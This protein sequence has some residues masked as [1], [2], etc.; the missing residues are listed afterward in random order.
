MVEPPVADWPVGCWMPRS[1][2]LSALRA[3]ARRSLLLAAGQSLAGLSELAARCG[4]S[5]PTPDGTDGLADS[6]SSRPLILTGHQPV[7]FHPGLVYKYQLTEAHAASA[8]GVSV[9]IVIDTDEGDPGQFAVPLV[10]TAATATAAAV[11]SGS[12]VETFAAGGGLYAGCRLLPKPDREAVVARVSADLTAAGCVEAGGAFEAAASRYLQLSDMPMW[13]ANTI[14]RRV[15]GIGS[16]MF[17]LPLTAV[18]RLPESL[19]LFA[20]VLSRAKDFHATYNHVLNAW[21]T[22]QGIRNE[23]NPFP[24]LRSTD[25]AI[26]LPFW[27]VEP[28][29]GRRSI[30]WLH[31]GTAGL[32]LGTEFGVVT[33]LTWGCEAEALLMLSLR[34]QLLV[35]RGALITASL[36]LLFGDL[37]VHG[38]GGGHYDP[39]TD[40]L[41]RS[42]WQEDPP[43]FAV[44]SASSCL[45]SEQRRQL[46][47]LD[48]FRQLFR[49]LQFNPGRYLDRG[50]FGLAEAAE[51]R[52][53]LEQK[54]S[55]VEELQRNRTAG[56]SGRETGRRIQQLSDTIRTRVATIFEHRVQAADGISEEAV[57]TIESRTWPWFYFHSDWHLQSD[58]N[59]PAL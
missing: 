7:I 36:R 51:I 38:L 33:E 5:L 9:A 49:D 22:K 29:A 3:S 47:Q 16:R 31:K 50:L 1:A 59:L 54:Q 42:W 48:E 58:S 52:G 41:I 4:L 10:S 6:L 34:G 46:R 43:P 26:E 2:S 15:F 35:P 17:E 30:V 11:V 28:A 20:G 56:V 8:G 12:R 55:A 40:E 27:L 23:A 37:F 53:L 25:A 14:V 57:S 24:N 19:R 18:C 39:A 13:A 45:F 32:A 21:R 44:A